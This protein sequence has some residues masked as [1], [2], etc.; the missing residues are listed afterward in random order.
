MRPVGATPK[1]A[2]ESLA[3]LQ[4]HFS[5]RLIRIKECAPHSPNL[6]PLLLLLFIEHLKT[7]PHNM[8]I[9]EFES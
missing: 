4:E 9:L 5:G 8:A 1:T 6:S 3:W 7:H 2:R